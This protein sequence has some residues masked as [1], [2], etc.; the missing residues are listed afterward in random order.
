[1]PQKL[2]AKNRFVD[3]D[4]AFTKVGDAPPYDIALKKDINSIQQSIKN[5]VLTS[6]GE[7]PFNRSFG[8][9]LVDLLFD[10]V[11]DDK[12]LSGLFNQIQYTLQVHEPRVVLDN[13]DVDT[14]NMDR[15]MLS[16]D[17]GYILAGEP[18]G[19]TGTIRSLTIELRRAR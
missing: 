8:G 9:N 17:L 10:N 2:I 15:N 19:E 7:K 1:M 16:L 4:L 18:K 5:I 3:F 14:S 11:A 6:V 12:V 13:I